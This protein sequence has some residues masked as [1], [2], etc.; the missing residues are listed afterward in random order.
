MK[1]Y[2]A[3]LGLPE[4][5]SEADIKRAFRKL[6]FKYHP[7][8]NPGNE[9]E[10]EARFKE[11]NEAYGVL[12]DSAKRQQYDTARKSPFAGTYRGA[13]SPGFGY[14]QQD[15][16]N[17]IFANRAMYEEMNRMFARAG[18]RFDPD[19][20]NRVYFSGRGMGFRFFTGPGG[21]YGSS[22]SSSTPARKPNWLERL[23]GRMVTGFFRFIVKSL[24]GLQSPYIPGANLDYHAD[25][26]ITHAEAESGTEKPLAFRRNGQVKNLMVKVPAGIRSGNKIRL[27]G[28]G[29]AA[30][31]KTGDLY[32]HVRIKD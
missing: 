22:P 1:E 6:A 7:D 21:A 17:G 11:I 18:L 13:G 30:G 14:S 2:Y 27:K 32:L 19:F 23:L 12:G 3:I 26:D 16:F 24:I 8:T 28:M 29:M 31:N 10:A 5:C 9:K 15:I 4:D 25:I 20:L